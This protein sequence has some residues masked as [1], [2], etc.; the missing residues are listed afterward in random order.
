MHK[1]LYKYYAYNSP[2]DI[3]IRLNYEKGNFLIVWAN[4]AENSYVGYIG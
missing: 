4:Y 1:V 2:K 3:C